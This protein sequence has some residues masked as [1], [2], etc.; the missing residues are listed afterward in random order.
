MLLTTAA[1]TLS[2]FA[3]HVYAEESGGNTEVSRLDNENYED[4]VARYNKKLEEYNK[5][6]EEY[7]KQVEANEAEYKI[8][9]HKSRPE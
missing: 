2:L 5:K 6:L 9:N 7:N 8:E 3:T 4:A 1:M